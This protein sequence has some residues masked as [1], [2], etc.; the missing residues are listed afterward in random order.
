[1]YCGVIRCA[2]V[3][4]L[5]F[6]SLCS[7][8]T[9]AAER[10]ETSERGFYVGASASRAE[11]DV[12]GEGEML[13]GVFGGPFGG[14]VMMLQPDQVDIDDVDV[15]WNVTLGYRIN[16]YLAAEL[17]YDDFGSVAVTERYFPAIWPLP[18]EISVHS[19]IDT[20]GP[21]L[22]LLGSWP[23]T[24][25]L[26]V[27][28]RGGVLFIDQE[29]E[30]SIDGSRTERRAGDET[31]VGGVGAQW[32]FASRW[33]ARLEYQRTGTID[34]GRSDTVAAGADKAE[35]LSLSVLFNL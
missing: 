14:F 1:M 28:V 18:D 17:S 2:T 20:F 30:R 25:A 4:L 7:E 21:R 29:L 15:G 31:W 8:I 22:S 5:V 11:Q 27:F 9:A 26:D 3:A 10:A 34:Y 33:T 19:A 16:Q 32:A 35:Q 24:P 23:V 13:V 6:V 12:V